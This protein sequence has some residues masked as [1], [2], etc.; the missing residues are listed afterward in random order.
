MARN[1]DDDGGRTSFGSLSNDLCGAVGE[2]GEVLGEEADEDTSDK[3][4]SKAH[5]DLPAE[6][7]SEHDQS[8]GTAVEHGSN[9][10]GGTDGREQVVLSLLVAL[11]LRQNVSDLLGAHAHAAHDGA[12]DTTSCKV[13]GGS[14]TRSTC[15]E[16]EV[17]NSHRET[18]ETTYRTWYHREWKRR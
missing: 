12:D 18:E 3:A 8:R 13:E 1:R 15:D 10:D 5:I 17:E 2:G 7:E 14:N 6:A 4:G 11:L 9:D 16:I